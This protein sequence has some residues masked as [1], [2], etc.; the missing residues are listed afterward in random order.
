MCRDELSRRRLAVGALLM[1]AGIAA[2]HYVGMAAMRMQPGI[3]YH[4]GW[5][6]LSI[7]IAVAASGA[8]LWITYRLRHDGPR[9]AFLRPLASVAMGLAIV[10]MHYTGMQAAGFPDDSV[11]LASNGGLSA[12]WL[13]I[14]VTAVTLSVL[15]IALIV[16]VLDNRLEARTSALASSLAEANEELVQLALHDTLTK[17]PN[18]ILLEDRMEQAIESASRRKGYFAVLFFDLDG[19]KAVNDAYGHHTG[20]ALLI[21]LAQRIRQTLRTQDTVARLGGDEFIVLSEVGEPTDAAS[22]ADRLINAIARPVTVYGHEVLVTSSVGIA[23]YPND[24]ED[25]HALLTNADAAMYHAKRLGGTGYSFFEPSMNADAHEQIELLHDL[26]LAQE[27]GQFVLH[28]QPKYEAPAGPIIGAEALL[29][30]NP[31]RGLVGPDLFIPTAE[32]T[33][34]ILSIGDWVINEACRQMREWIDAGQSHWTIAVNISA[35]QFAHASLVETVRGALARHNVPPSCLTLEVTEST[36]MRDAEASLA[37]LK[38]LSGL[39]VTI[40]IDDFGTGY[41][42]LLYLKRLPATEL[43]IDRGFVNQLENDNEDAAIV[44]A[45]VALA[46]QLNL[47]IVAEGVETTAQ[48]KFLTGLGC[49]SLQ[50]FLLGKP[51]PATEFLEHANG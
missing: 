27:R 12:G 37:V 38:R 31:T 9:M 51:M 17:L 45:I 42:S 26:R 36:A 8:A 23:I 33:G 14:A 15:G 18:R 32:K 30:W 16:A 40:S 7:L 41:S 20:D 6:A 43:K 22:V 44:S 48:Q 46:Q 11:C 50:G 5:F 29:R 34:L 2:M 24:G 35:L 3:V 1:G 25:T 49:D 39:G 47:R 13:A 28:Y 4:R 21:D 10:G 19:F